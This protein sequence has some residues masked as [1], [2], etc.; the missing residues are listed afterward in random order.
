LSSE[1]L[2]DFGT[3]VESW[4]P[5]QAIFF[6]LL[7]QTHSASLLLKISLPVKMNAAQ[8]RAAL[9]LSNQQGLSEAFYQQRQQL[10]QRQQQ[11]LLQQ[12]RQQLLQQQHLRQQELQRD[13][14][15]RQLL[16]QEQLA[17]R[18][19]LQL[20]AMGDQLSD[21]PD[22]QQ[23]YQTL[24]AEDRLQR[25]R[26]NPAIDSS[27][28][29]GLAGSVH[30]MAS[31]QQQQQVALLRERE[32]LRAYEE[33]LLLQ[34]RQQQLKLSASFRDDDITQTSVVGSLPTSV[35]LQGT[36][37]RQNSSQLQHIHI[38]PR[39]SPQRSFPQSDIA[40]VDLSGTSHTNGEVTLH[41]AS[42]DTVQEDFLNE[43]EHSSD[44]S[45]L[46]DVKAGK[47]RKRL[48]SEQSFGSMEKPVDG[49]KSKKKKSFSKRSKR[50]AYRDQDD[51]SSAPSPAHFY[52]DDLYFTEN[53]IETL[54]HVA[55][56][57]S[58]E[59]TSVLKGTFDDILEA[60]EENE[61][62]ETAAM[63][64]LKEFSEVEPWPDSDGEVVVVDEKTE[65]DISF[66][67]VKK[68]GTPIVSICLPKFKSILPNLPS[69]PLLEDEASS[70]GQ[71]IP[72]ISERNNQEALEV[73]PT[74]PKQVAKV[75]KMIANE[76]PYPVDTWWPSIGGMRRERKSCGETTDEDAFE[77]EA[78]VEGE[79]RL[80]RAN[81][82]KIKNR[83]SRLAQPGV[84]EKLPHCRVHRIKTK[85]KKNSNAPELV[86][87]WQVTELYPNELMVN[88]SGC[89]TWRHVACGGQYKP[90]SVRENSKVPFVA[91]CENCHE[92]EKYIEEYPRGAKRI[93]R[94]RAEQ[95][96][97]GLASSTVM[98]YTSYSKH[99]G[100]YKWPLGSVSATHIG[101]HTRS[102]QA[103][104]DKGEKQ[105]N[106]MASRL[107][108]GFGYRIKE[109]VRSRTKELERLLVAIEDAE[110]FTDRHNMLV[111]LQRDTSKEKPAGFEEETRNFFD[112]ADDCDIDTEPPMLSVASDVVTPM[113]NDKKLNDEDD[114]DVVSAESGTSPSFGNPGKME[115]VRIGC[116]G[117]R[118]YDSRFCSD[119]C[120]VSTL[121]TSL[122]RALQDASDLHPSVLRHS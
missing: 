21:F 76:Y 98:R 8:M 40:T 100:T 105:W 25:Q 82:R 95:L 32:R 26:Q 7:C 74:A 103:R 70:F 38:L 84:L 18:Q 72:N 33:Q 112:P 109:R 34:Q 46:R 78:G 77:D 73:E 93:E 47:T 28:V 16:L 44:P 50:V 116:E 86:Y 53:V 117:R 120:G 87:C 13:I 63:I 9:G 119:A 19:E 101:G 64:L 66:D 65:D 22:L 83:L 1:V 97:R 106:D 14:Q 17:Q 110:G 99:G 35:L 122:L 90:Y 68:S 96:R 11:L 118:R 6:D 36:S 91:V 3:L 81:T 49:K 80:F 61:H 39:P 24:L 75:K 58:Y 10:Q 5:L 85:R 102:V 37:P 59:E 31:A 121:E 23:H 62:M 29:G 104:H 55:D 48:N 54:A 69:E 60:A 30:Q 15:L 89:G 107:Y 108:R 71:D 56:M 42:Q 115:C 43:H 45:T 27:S 114:I 52:R 57:A 113:K 67:G 79:K 94:Q 88:C 4:F 2:Y 41:Q 111:F 20:R 51:L 92:E 12:Q